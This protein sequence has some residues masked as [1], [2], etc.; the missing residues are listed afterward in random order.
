M[1]GDPDADQTKCWDNDLPCMMKKANF[2]YEFF[3][4]NTG[5]DGKRWLETSAGD[6]KVFQKLRK[7]TL[8]LNSDHLYNTNVM[9]NDYDLYV[10]KRISFDVTGSSLWMYQRPADFRCGEESTNRDEPLVS[11]NDGVKLTLNIDGK[12]ETLKLKR[13]YTR[14]QLKEHED[15]AQCNSLK[16][17]LMD[18]DYDKITLRLKDYDKIQEEYVQFKNKMRSGNLTTTFLKNSIKETSSANLRCTKEKKTDGQLCMPKFKSFSARGGIN[19]AVLPSG[20][21]AFVVPHLLCMDTFNSK[22]LNRNCK[23]IIE[24]KGEVFDKKSSSQFVHYFDWTEADQSCEGTCVAKFTQKDADGET[25]NICRTRDGNCDDDGN[26]SFNPS[27]RA[28]SGRDEFTFEC[29][30]GEKCNK[31]RSKT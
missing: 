8:T 21:Q 3:G 1:K 2:S 22:G 13:E 10:G 31:K 11:F 23:S 19:P 24:E 27:N 26:S 18:K 15:A 25:L 4:G 7:G 16:A 30:S 12:D 17:K 28:S 20:Y 5:E 9:W 6:M 29:C 14:T